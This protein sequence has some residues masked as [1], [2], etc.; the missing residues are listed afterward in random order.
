[1]NFIRVIAA[2]AAVSLVGCGTSANDPV[3]VSGTGM[4]ELGIP[5]EISD[6]TDVVTTVS[7]PD[8]AAPIVAH[9]AV[10]GDMATGLIAGIPAGLDRTFSVHAYVGTVLVCTGTEMVEIVAEARVTVSMMLDCSVPPSSTGE[11][12]VVAGFNFPPEIISM[13]ATPSPVMVGGVVEFEV[14]A[15][16]PNGDTLTYAWTATDGAFSVPDAPATSWTAP[17]TAGNYDVTIEISDGVTIVSLT[18]TIVVV[19]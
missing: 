3:K 13:T 6:I 19:S 7:A 5:L 15:T 14:A 1:M 16:D 17:M 4:A 18:I 9:L 2:V 10:I 11:A 8:I 12:E